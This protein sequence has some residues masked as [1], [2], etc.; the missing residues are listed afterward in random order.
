M[1]DLLFPLISQAGSEE[2]GFFGYISENHIELTIKGQYDYG[3][4]IIMFESQVSGFQI[5]DELREAARAE[6]KRRYPEAEHKVKEG[7]IFQGWAQRAH[8]FAH[9]GLIT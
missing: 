3:L 8:I 1:S 6:W 2:I 9:T 4:F 7:M 5:T